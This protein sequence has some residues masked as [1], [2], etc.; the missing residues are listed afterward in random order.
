MTKET[1]PPLEQLRDIRRMMERTSKF[2]GLSG[3]SGIGAGVFALVGALFAY[4]Y[5]AV[6][7]GGS[8]GDALQYWPAG[9]HPWGWSPLEFFVLDAVFVLAGAL[10]SGVYFTTRRAR[11]KGQAIWDA[12]TRRLLVNL[13]IPL[14]AGG[15]FCLALY[16][17][18]AVGWVAPA[19]LIFYGL[20]LINGSKFTLDEVLYLGIMELVLGLVGMFFIGW[21]LLLWAIGFGVLHIVYGVV[22]YLKYE[23][24][25]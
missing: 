23:Q 20:A 9:G 18:G 2:I 3:L 12:L 17:H 8:Y 24:S 22:M 7:G 5:M 15:V 16:Y 6:A 21:G 25:V 13:G 14:A 11:R 19:T 1:I 4:L 10:S